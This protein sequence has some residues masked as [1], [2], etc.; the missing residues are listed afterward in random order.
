MKV[1]SNLGA[2]FLEVVYQEALQDELLHQEIPHKR[3]VKLNIHYNGKLLK[4][5]YI[6]DFVCYDKII[7]EIKSSQF[8]HN[9]QI[10]QIL[11]YVKATK[12]ELGILV[13][14]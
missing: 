9:N 11:N 6:A 14:F 13:N 1:H 2:G 5:Y 8:L 10:K 4:K 3:Q 7:A 12:Y